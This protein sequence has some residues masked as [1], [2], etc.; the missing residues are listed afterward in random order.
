[1]SARA[2]LQALLVVLLAR[3]LGKQDYGIYVAILSISGFFSVLVG[4]GAS[5][6]HLRDVSLDP[7][8]WRESYVRRHRAIYLS[9]VWLI[10]VSLPIAWF[11]AKAGANWLEIVLLVVGDVAALSASEFMV[12]SCQG[13]L[14]FRR[15]A[16]M[17]CMLP[18]LRVLVLG[19]AI[20]SGLRLDLWGWSI[21][22]CA[23]G[24]A[25]SALAAFGARRAGKSASP[26][27]R[28]E[29]S[30]LAGLG[31]AMAAGSAR[32]HADADKAI[33]AKLS[34]Y[35]LAGEYSIAYR[36]MDVL[37]LPV[38]GFVEWS[39]G[40]LFQQGQCGFSQ[41]LRKLNWRW[42]LLFLVAA[43]IGAVSWA[44]APLLPWVFGK[45]FDGTVAMA[46]WLSLLPL[47]A[48]T[49]TC[50]RCVAATSGHERAVG[51]IELLGAGFS[52][53]LGIALVLLMGWK[54]AILAT[55]ATHMTMT[56]VM[57]AVGLRPD[58][59]KMNSRR[60]CHT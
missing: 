58:R 7:E 51:V 53:A 38:N 56:V 16:A 33:I 36:M 29:G 42:L 27:T 4:I 14:L 10:A 54:G 11:V 15:M 17:M 49:W 3:L 20:L 18:G 12:R 19:A 34:S 1:M 8:T 24:G 57:L 44:L 47:S 60:G 31:F 43:A 6:L 41:S 26:S 48:A 2:F 35:G 30:H 25:M 32:I 37:L 50:V 23:T 21:V 55:Y 13:R 59:R 52:V 5:A 22:C 45:A 46:H 28:L 9:Q 39:T 40:A